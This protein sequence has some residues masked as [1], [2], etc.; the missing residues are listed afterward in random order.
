MAAGAGYAVLWATF[1][2]CTLI[3]FPNTTALCVMWS[4]LPSL[5]GSIVAVS[6][7]LSNSVGVLAAICLASQSFGVGWICMYSWST[8]TAGSSFTKRLARQALV[9][10][11]Y[12]VANIVSPQLWQDRDA[13]KYVPA[14]T[15][16]I[17]L[18]FTVS[19]AIIGLVWHLLA[20][21][22]RARLAALDAHAGRDAVGYVIDS[23]GNR[24][25]V[26]TA[27]LDATDLEDPTFVYPT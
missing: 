25:A 26:N 14:W 24:V 19:P 18:S 23:D 8:T 2:T 10:V 1:A 11:A 22:N 13:P 6:L 7:P 16:Q 15:V 12:S 3:I 21:R 5:V 4:T 27:A 17:V 20:R 9:L